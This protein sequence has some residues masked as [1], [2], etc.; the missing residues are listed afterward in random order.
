MEQVKV[1]VLDQKIAVD[2]GSPMKDI[3]V[4]IKSPYRVMGGIVDNE[5]Q[6]LNYL[7]EKDCHIKFIDMTTP[8]GI[9]IYERSLLF[10]L[11]RAVKAILPKEELSV[12][13]SLGGGIYCEFRNNKKL[14]KDELDQII[15]QIDRIIKEDIPFKKVN[16]NKKTQNI[17]LDDKKRH[18]FEFIQEDKIQLYELNGQYEYFNGHILPSTGWLDK[19]ELRYYYP[20]FVL[21][22]PSSNNPTQ[23]N[24]FIDQKKLFH[25]FSEYEKWCKF[26]DVYDVLSLNKKIRDNTIVEFIR[27]A[28]AYHEHE[29]NNIAQ[30]IYDNKDRIKLVIISGPSSA[31]KTTTSKRLKTNLMVR[32]IMPLTIELDNYFVNREETP[33]DENGNLDFENID[34][35]DIELFNENLI[36]LIENKEVEMPVFNFLE[37]KRDKKGRRVKIIGNNPIIIEGIHGLNEKLT[38]YI[39]KEN[40]YKIYINTLTQLNI[41]SYNRI[42]TSDIRLLRRMI[43]DYKYRGHSAEDTLSMWESVRLGEEKNIFPYQEEADYIFNSALFYEIFV[44]KKYAQ[45]LLKQIHPDNVL[46]P[47][48]KRILDFFEFFLTIEDETSILTNS[49]LREFIGGSIY[50]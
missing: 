43:R 6:D 18:L 40:K 2:K 26:L 35:I 46:F 28:E 17:K 23:I 42:P 50:T 21:L 7:I 15:L 24:N 41:D 39:P 8:L 49:I 9:K 5:L 31:G 12:E 33:K 22:H 38:K 4:L 45:P 25:V 1:T 30:E 20:G 44:L 14:K 19:F 29:I 36:Q 48:A 47:Q 10:V 11:V 27:V 13:H 37:G 3:L 32:G 34:A 16:Y